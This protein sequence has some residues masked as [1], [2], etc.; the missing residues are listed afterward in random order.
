MLPYRWVQ[1]KN[2][3]WVKVYLGDRD[4]HNGLTD[5]E[6]FDKWQALD[7]IFNKQAN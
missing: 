6:L 3:Q 5:A 2:G 1:D 7:K 4:F